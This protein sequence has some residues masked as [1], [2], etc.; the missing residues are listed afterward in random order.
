MDPSFNFKDDYIKNFMNTTEKLRKSKR[1]QFLQ[2]R[3]KIKIVNNK[4]AILK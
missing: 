3:R 1:T 4:Q 2:D